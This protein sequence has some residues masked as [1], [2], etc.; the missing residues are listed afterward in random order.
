[1]AYRVFLW[2]RQVNLSSQTT[3]GKPL[4]LWPVYANSSLGPSKWPTNESELAAIHL[5]H[6]LKLRA[7]GRD[8]SEL[9][10]LHTRPW[11]RMHNGG[12]LRDTVVVVC[13]QQWANV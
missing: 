13:G 6:F 9:Q 7:F 5:H 3:I 4:Y 8:D 2:P 11:R 12:S 10:R 1:M